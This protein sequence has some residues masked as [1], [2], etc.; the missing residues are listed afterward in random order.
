MWKERL[1]QQCM[2]VC[3]AL[4]RIRVGSL[5]HAHSGSTAT[6]GASSAGRKTKRPGPK[7]LL[8]FGVDGARGV[9]QG[10]H[11]VAITPKRREHHRSAA[12][13]CCASA[14]STSFRLAAPLPRCQLTWCHP[15]LPLPGNPGTHTRPAR[16][17]RHSSSHPPPLA[18][19]HRS[20]RPFL[21]E[22]RGTH[23]PPACIQ[24]PRRAVAPRHRCPEPCRHRRRRRRPRWAGPSR[25]SSTARGSTAALRAGRTPP[26]TTTSFPRQGP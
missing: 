5:H 15:G 22:A 6:W 20:H 19:A 3:Q 10:D 2:C 16:E 4:W 25:S 26:T 11:S 21:G 18:A 24:E 17:R 14:A 23:L 8:A 13:H 1:P 12:A 7:Q 9:C